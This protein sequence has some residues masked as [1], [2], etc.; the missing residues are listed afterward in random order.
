MLHTAAL[1]ALLVVVGL[2]IGS[3]P[4]VLHRCGEVCEYHCLACGECYCEVCDGGFGCKGELSSNPFLPLRAEDH[5]ARLGLPRIS[6]EAGNAASYTPPSL[7]RFRTAA[8]RGPASAPA[9]W[10]WQMT[11]EE[12][13]QS[14]SIRASGKAYS[15]QCKR[16]ARMLDDYKTRDKTREKERDQLRDRSQR[17]QTERKRPRRQAP[18]ESVPNYGA[19]SLTAGGPVVPLLRGAGADYLDSKL[20]TLPLLRG[21]GI[22]IERLQTQPATS[23]EYFAPRPQVQEATMDILAVA[24]AS[25]LRA[26][27]EAFVFHASSR[28]KSTRIAAPSAGDGQT[29]RNK[30]TQPPLGA[31]MGFEWGPPPSSPHPSP[32]PPPPSPSRRWPRTPGRVRLSARVLESRTLSMAAGLG[33][34]RTLVCTTAMLV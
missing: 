24:P 22:S 29:L 3:V 2:A 1:P 20:F 21:G 30:D 18:L 5:A 14:V 4:C 27:A 26:D 6:G 8:A 13:D 23:A 17:D 33:S 15:I 16:H 28:F 9:L 34:R 7:H 31:C 12:W 32:P 25:E 19:L 11:G 10:Y